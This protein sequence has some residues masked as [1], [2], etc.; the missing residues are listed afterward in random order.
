MLNVLTTTLFN[1]VNIDVKYQ[2]RF[3]DIEVM[4]VL[5]LET[6]KNI[7]VLIT[8]IESQLGLRIW[9][10]LLEECLDDARIAEGIY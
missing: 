5:C 2:G 6:N 8:D 3:P 1:L 10:Q 9:D 7:N 4:S